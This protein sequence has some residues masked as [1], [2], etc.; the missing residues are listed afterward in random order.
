MTVRKKIAGLVAAVGLLAGGFAITAGA[1]TAGAA[2]AAPEPQAPANAVA[3]DGRT[4]EALDQWECKKDR[5][6][7]WKGKYGTGKRCMWRHKDPKWLGGAIRCEWSDAAIV[8]SV[9]NR[10]GGWEGVV[11]YY[12][13]KYGNRIGC[14]QAGQ[15]GNFEG[16]FAP[17]SHKW[18]DGSCG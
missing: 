6:C 18:T 16:E 2:N 11:Y 3:W 13:N 15:K 9:W 12:N 4:G 10:K 5:V 1:S 14:T 8:R 7:F 17:R